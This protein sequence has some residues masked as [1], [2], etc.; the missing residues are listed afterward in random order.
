MP[1]MEAIQSATMTPA[2]MLGI[3][4]EL[5][6]IEAGKYADIIATNENPL[7]EIE[8]MQRVSFVMKGGK[9]YKQ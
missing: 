5:G 8:T 4:D 6:S 9:V 2:I 1:A 7:E 3:E